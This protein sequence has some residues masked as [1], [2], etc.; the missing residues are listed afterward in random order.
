MLAGEVKVAKILHV[1]H[2]ASWAEYLF[3][4][5]FYQRQATLNI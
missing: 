1:L 2:G 3:I 4:S 5:P